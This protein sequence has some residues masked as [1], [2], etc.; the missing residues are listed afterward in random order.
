MT[1][2]LMIFCA[3]ALFV[4]WLLVCLTVSALT[5][6]VSVEHYSHIWIIFLCAVDLLFWVGIPVLALKLI[7]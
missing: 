5:T 1:T 2:I 6:R 4:I 7:L 3:M